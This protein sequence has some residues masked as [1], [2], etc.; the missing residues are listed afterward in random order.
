MR[1]IT[2]QNTKQENKGNNNYVSKSVNKPMK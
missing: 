2:S 1:K